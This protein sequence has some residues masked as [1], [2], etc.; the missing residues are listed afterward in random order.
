MIE[1]EIYIYIYIYIYK[2]KKREN[3][4]K[5]FIVLVSE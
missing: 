1:E 2:I 3:F 4:N 5:F